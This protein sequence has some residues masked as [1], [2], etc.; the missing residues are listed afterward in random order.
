VNL[1]VVQMDGD[2]A[3]IE[4]TATHPL[5]RLTSAAFAV[6]GKKWTPVFPNDGLFDSK[7]ETF[8]FQTESLKPGLYVVVLRV[9]DAAGNTGSGDVV[10][11]VPA[12]SGK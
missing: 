8:R 7:S 6:N 4:A 12:R 5:A 9:K 11:S 1:K 2:R 10:F 3:V